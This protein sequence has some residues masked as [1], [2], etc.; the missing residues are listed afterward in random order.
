MYPD[1]A[2]VKETHETDSQ[3]K[4]MKKAKGGGIV[5]VRC[6]EAFTTTWI[7]GTD[8]GKHTRTGTEVEDGDE[9][10]TNCTTG[11]PAV[12][13][14]SGLEGGSFREHTTHTSPEP[15]TRK[16]APSH[17]SRGH[18]AQRPPSSNASPSPPVL[19]QRSQIGR[20]HAMDHFHDQNYRQEGLFSD[21]C[22]HSLSPT[23]E[24]TNE[25]P[26]WASLTRTIPNPGEYAQVI[27]RVWRASY[28]SA[29]LHG[30]KTEIRLPPGSVEIQLPS[31]DGTDEPTS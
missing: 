18:R 5:P 24:R 17:N 11:T 2:V 6:W 30:Q 9:T 28:E 4:H 8:S 13:P 14:G 31:Q 19:S 22:A 25:A 3:D 12:V 27:M 7:T 20:A 26:L 29:A 23:T 16:L 1:V 10:G 21:T 15:D